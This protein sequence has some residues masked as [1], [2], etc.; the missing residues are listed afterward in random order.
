MISI[1]ITEHFNDIIRNENINWLN[2]SQN[3]QLTWDFIK[4][5]LDRKWD[6]SYLSSLDKI[7]FDIID[8][9]INLPWD[10]IV[11]SKRISEFDFVHKYIDKPWDWNYISFKYK[12]PIDILTLV[13][14]SYELGSYKLNW[15][16]LS[17]KYSDIEIS[18]NIQLN[19]YWNIIFTDRTIESLNVILQNIDI[20]TDD[21]L[22]KIANCICYD[23]KIVHKIPWKLIIKLDHSRWDWSRLSS[24]LDLSLECILKYPNKYWNWKIISKNKV[25]TWDFVY[26][27]K[28]LPWDYDFLSNNP[29]ITLDNIKQT[30]FNKWNYD[31][32]QANPN[33][34]LSNTDLIQ[35]IKKH[36]AIC[37]IQRAYKKCYYNS[38]YLI[39]R[40]RLLRELDILNTYCVAV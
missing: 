25:I 16:T 23:D 28:Q 21:I 33:F 10:Y 2:L 29:N 11:L 30:P 36:H 3:P 35:I 38:D 17:K 4:Q 12:I 37:V 40:K 20:L 26:K 1:L 6:W 14:S 22:I 9:N 31:V 24:R 18:E 15:Y 39:C 7:T 34:L 5:Y 32:F 27:N 13:N 8:S 19:W